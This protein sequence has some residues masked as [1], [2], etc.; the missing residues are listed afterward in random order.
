MLAQTHLK[1]IQASHSVPPPLPA[2]SPDPLFPTCSSQALQ[3]GTCSS[4]VEEEVDNDVPGVL[5]ADLTAHLEDHAGEEPVE[6]T[7]GV[8]ALVVGGDG[9][10]H[11]GQ[12]G[13][14]V[15]ECDG[16]DV[17]VG[18]LLDRLVI[19]AGVRQ[20]QQPRLLELLLDLICEGTCRQ[21]G[22]LSTDC[23]EGG[24]DH[25]MCAKNPG[26]QFC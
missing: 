4:P 13:V 3:T 23:R 18:C 21:P 25:L 17:H 22:D 5:G 2:G 20:D 10:I 7:D 19:G 16:G 15:T 12:V 11:E 8:L 9:H 24:N 14:R 6:D 1:H 26:L